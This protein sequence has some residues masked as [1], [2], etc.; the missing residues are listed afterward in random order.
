MLQSYFLIIR[1]NEFCNKG[2]KMLILNFYFVCRFCMNIY[3][4]CYLPPTSWFAAAMQEADFAI[5]LA[6]NYQKQQLTNRCIIKT[7]L[8]VLPLV[9]PVARVGGKQTIQDTQIANETP[10]QRIHWKSIVTAYK[11][12]PY[13]EHYEDKFLPFYQKKYSFLQD[14]NLG[15]QDTCCKILK[16][17]LNIIY[18][19]TYQAAD[20]YEKDFRQS[21]K[22]APID[23]QAI[24]Y[25]QVF[26]EFTPN[27]SIIDFIFNAGARGRLI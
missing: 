18:S 26:G 8:G 21:F 6:A 1:T 11:N 20:C 14:F 23:Y 19:T 5:E 22:V 24:P 12:A 4:F 27:L 13:F 15:L 9:I 25:Q 7:S 3:P 16:V 2:R 17:Q 10:W